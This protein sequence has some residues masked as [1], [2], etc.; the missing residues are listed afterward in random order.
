MR[1]ILGALVEARSALPARSLS[2]VDLVRAGWPDER[3][4]PDAAK[5]R[6]HVMLTRLRGHGLRGVLVGDDLGYALAREVSIEVVE[7]DDAFR[8]R[9]DDGGDRA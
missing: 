3:I 2:A 1:R 5:N 8:S 4:R 9:R 6:L 7:E